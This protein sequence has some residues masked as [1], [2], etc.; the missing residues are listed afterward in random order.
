MRVGWCGMR[1]LGAGCGCAGAG[2]GWAGLSAISIMRKKVFIL[3]W[4][5]KVGRVIVGEMDW[6]GAC[7]DG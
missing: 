5:F 7:L 1:A 4:R 2:C 6:A 3:G